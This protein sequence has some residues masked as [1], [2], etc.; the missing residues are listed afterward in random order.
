MQPSSSRAEAG[1]WVKAAGRRQTRGQKE[2]LYPG[3]CCLSLAWSASEDVNPRTRRIKQKAGDPLAPV[4]KDL[5][6]PM[7]IPLHPLRGL[8]ALEP[9][10]DSITLP[11]SSSQ[12]VPLCPWTCRIQ[13]GYGWVRTL[14]GGAQWASWGLGKPPRPELAG[15]RSSCALAACRLPSTE[16]C[17]SGLSFPSNL[18]NSSGYNLF[19][20]R[21]RREAQIRGGRY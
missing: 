18:S 21:H 1:S 7:R 20:P 11:P 5:R 2:G 9:I 8:P 19:P 6:A 10:P 13:H 12:R 14:G 4:S 17:V 15:G 16:P 3:Q